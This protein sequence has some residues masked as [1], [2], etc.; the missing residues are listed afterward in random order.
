[1]R[2]T[3]LSW[4]MWAAWMTSFSTAWGQFSPET[5]PETDW[6]VSF[7]TGFFSEGT[8]L[9]TKVA[10]EPVSVRTKSAWLVGLRAGADKEFWGAE[11]TLA[12]I[13]ADLELVAD[14]A[15]L[16]P[17]GGDANLLLLDLNFLWYP[18]GN[19]LADGRVRPFVT[20]GPGFMFFNSDFDQADGE[21]AFDVN[22]GGGIK[23]LLGEKGNPFLRFDYR[24]H[25]FYG[26]TS[27]LEQTIYRQ[28]MTAGIGWRF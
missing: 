24:W 2:A 13:F 22:F 10:Q 5:A 26:M 15:A 17:S 20:L 25:I 3:N 18:T 19:D 9:R 11:L 4:I 21:S 7:N 27:G 14:P 1:M 6:Q 12:E 28:E 16:L 23:F 8:Y